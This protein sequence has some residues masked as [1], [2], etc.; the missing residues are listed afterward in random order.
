M[1]FKTLFGNWNL[2]NT[3]WIQFSNIELH[4]TFVELLLSNHPYLHRIS[5]AQSTAPPAP[6]QLRGEIF[7]QTFSQI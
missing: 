6:R 5:I 7:G 2:Q 3:R 4:S 1:E